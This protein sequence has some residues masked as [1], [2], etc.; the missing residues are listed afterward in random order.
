MLMS[1][2]PCAPDLPRAVR[3][4]A[5]LAGL[6]KFLENAA[7]GLHWWIVEHLEDGL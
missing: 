7:P 1:A 5:D 6:D 2:S 4:A 3:L